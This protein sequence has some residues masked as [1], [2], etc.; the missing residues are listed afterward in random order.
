MTL[1]RGVALTLAAAGLFLPMHATSG[2]IG[3]QLPISYIDQGISWQE[4]QFWSDLS[5]LGTLNHH[6]LLSTASA[7]AVATPEPRV[8]ISGSTS[9]SSY[10]VVADVYM[11]YDFAILSGQTGYANVLINSNAGANGVGSYLATAEVDLVGYGGPLVYAHACNNVGYCS[12]VYTASVDKAASIQMNHIYTF[13][14]HVNAHTA[15]SNS[16]FFAFA[17]PK[18]TFDP[19]YQIP[20]GAQIV[21]SPGFTP[22]VPEP[23]SWA[24]LLTGFGFVGGMARMGR[25]TKVAV[26]G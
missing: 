15:Y 23:A 7:S 24:L 12:N 6:D 20:A 2:P 11:T 3:L 25:R 16:E 4:G 21:Y 18:V 13:R 19:A 10:I 8:E 22:G 9:A 1:S 14:L 17:D 5:G 26:A